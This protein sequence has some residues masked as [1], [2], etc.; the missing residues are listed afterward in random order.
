MHAAVQAVEPRLAL[1]GLSTAEGLDGDIREASRVESASHSLGRKL[2]I[3]AQVTGYAAYSDALVSTAQRQLSRAERIG[4][5]VVALIMLLM[6]GSVVAAALPVAIGLSAVIF[7]LGTVGLLARWFAVSEFVANATVMLGL[8]LGVDY[9]MFLLKRMREF[10]AEGKDV[11]AAVTGAMGTT[12]RAVGFSG[13]VV[14]ASQAVLFT[15]DVRAVRSM[16]LGT[17]VATAAALATALVMA[18]AL[19]LVLGPRLDAPSGFL[20]R[21]SR[22][23]PR[24]GRRRIAAQIVERPGLALVGTTLLLA[25]LAVPALRLPDH[26][27]V[28][29]VDILP[30]GTEA[31]DAYDRAASVVGPGRLGPIEIVFRESRSTP[32]DLHRRVRDFSRRIVQDP[33]VA[34]VEP[35]DTPGRG[36]AGLA[37]IPTVDPYSRRAEA[38][39]ERIR[40]QRPRLAAAGVSMVLGG[41]TAQ[42]LDSRAGMFT[43]LP[44]VL[45]GIAAVMVVLLAMAFRSV[46][47]PL[48]AVL[49][50]AL[51]LGATFGVIGLGST[52][53]ISPVVPIVLIA[54][55]VALSAD[56][57]LLLILRMRE[58][59]LSG[60]G[61]AESIVGGLSATARVIT[62]AAVV[63]I[64]VFVSFGVVGVTTV[65]QLSLGLAVAVL[66]DATV[67]R[68]V[69][70]PSA[71][72]LLGSY[73]WWWPGRGRSSALR[74]THRN[75]PRVSRPVRHSEG[76]AGE[77]SETDAADGDRAAGRRRSL[78]KT[79]LWRP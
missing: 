53:P 52:A 2:G 69:M 42:S 6:F 15:V 61:N 21:R 29:N 56:Y 7:A 55:A 67:V 58:L 10:R 76:A 75:C 32:A 17:T 47:L 41:P 13:L 51:V 24:R 73:N 8:A 16:A 79:L 20:R 48:K 19:M 1:V 35:L 59:Y 65:R 26:V 30:V 64:A 60:A 68:L 46:V 45:G 72:I 44:R 23:T 63:M 9:S 31:R 54:V 34:D 49:L 43:V 25:A 28:P 12:G 70:V 66:L 38:L 71:M 74:T 18:P 5:P 40:T 3:K 50:L 11:A 36:T 33:S 77:G 4:L 39:V 57:E 14:L 37:V 22:R 27:A 62:S 78:G